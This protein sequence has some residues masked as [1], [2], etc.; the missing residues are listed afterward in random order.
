[1]AAS[2]NWAAAC[3]NHSP[4]RSGKNGGRRRATRY[5]TAR[6]VL[7]GDSY[8]FFAR[9]GHQLLIYGRFG[10]ILSVNLLASFDSDLL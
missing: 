8:V 1:M 5:I 10:I 4:G 2:S 7:A 6:G 9:R 3:A